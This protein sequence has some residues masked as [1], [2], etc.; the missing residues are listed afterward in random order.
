M[1]LEVPPG[2]MSGFSLFVRRPIRWEN[3]QGAAVMWATSFYP[4]WSC[5]ESA[6]KAA[7]AS[8][9][10]EKL[11]IDANV[12]YL[13]AKSG[14]DEVSSETF[15]TVFSNRHYVLLRRVA[16]KVRAPLCPEP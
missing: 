8:G 4:T 11:A 9:G 3:S 15:V 5:R 10:L 13:I 14:N 1:F 2:K 12:E 16:A 6:V 7:L